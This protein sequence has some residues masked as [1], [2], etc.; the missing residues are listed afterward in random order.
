VSEVDLHH[1][2]DLVTRRGCAPDVAAEILL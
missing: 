1:A 2:V